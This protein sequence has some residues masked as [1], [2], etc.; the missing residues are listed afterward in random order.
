MSEK[1]IQ[2]MLPEFSEPI[3]PGNSVR[4][5]QM[6]DDQFGHEDTTE[7]AAGH[8]VGQVGQVVGL[9]PKHRYPFRVRFTDGSE[10]MY[11]YDELEL[12]K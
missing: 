5:A 3:L 11:H 12:L 7:W 8:Y 9:E 10:F 4:V 1:W 6:Y 2:D